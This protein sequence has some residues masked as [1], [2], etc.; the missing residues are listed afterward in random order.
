MSCWHKAV[1]LGRAERPAPPDNTAQ[2]ATT[3]TDDL[4]TKKNIFPAAG[5]SPTA[6][7]KPSSRRTSG[8]RRLLL[9]SRRTGRRRQQALQQPPQPP[10]LPPPQP[11]Q[12]TRRLFLPVL[13]PVEQQRGWRLPLATPSSCAVSGGTASSLVLVP[14]RPDDEPARLAELEDG[15]PPIAAV[16]FL[17]RRWPPPSPLLLLLLPGRAITFGVLPAARETGRKSPRPWPQKICHRLRV[18]TPGLMAASSIP[19]GLLFRRRCCCAKRA[20]ET[21]SNGGVGAHRERGGV[22][23]GSC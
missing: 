23:V 15:G 21:A 9:A 5:P 7:G 13:L 19:V 1:T 2:H 14:T 8:R 12:E 18:P 10:P 6:A 4:L 17:F 11:H 20:G 22:G 16:A 3:M